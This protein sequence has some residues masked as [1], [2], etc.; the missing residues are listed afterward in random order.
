MKFGAF[1]HNLVPA[2]SSPEQDPQPDPEPY[3]ESP[4][5]YPPGGEDPPEEAPPE[6]DSHGELFELACTLVSANT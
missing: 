1:A 6:E 4:N 5:R 3:S 2:L